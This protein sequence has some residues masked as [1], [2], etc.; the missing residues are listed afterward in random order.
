MKPSPELLDLTVDRPVHGGRC[1]AYPDGS[2]AGVANGADVGSERAARRRVVLVAGAIPG[3]RVRARVEVRKGVAFGDTVAVLAAD[4]QR[5]EPPAHPGLDLGHVAYARQLVWK[6]DVLEDALRRSGL[7]APVEGDGGG[8]DVVPSPATWGYRNAIQPAVGELGGHGPAGGDPAEATA[9][10]YRRPGGH[11]VVALEADPTA[12][13]ACRTAW[14]AL[15]A[16]R[17]P[18]GVVEVSLRG[19]DAGEALATFVATTEARA[20]LDA[21]QALV[22]AGVHGVGLAPYDARGRFR[23]G[24]QR[25]AGARTLLQR[26][27]DVELTLTATAFAQPNPAAAGALFRELA[28]WAPAARHALDLYAGSGVIG[29]H[30]APRVDRVTCLE[31]DRGAV[32]RGRADAAR[33]GLTNVQHVRLDVRDVQVPDDVDLIVVDP[34]RAGLAAATRAAIA[35]SRARTLLYV[36]C[37]VATWARDVADLTRVGFRLDRLRPYDFQPHTHHLEIASRL[38]RGGS[39]GR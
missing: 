2:E 11:D 3:E 17:L 10:G 22:A 27:G 4:G 35:G 18:R 13:E 24:A 9:L 12:N 39:A 21:A 28:A 19:N 37:D 33:L 36:A 38:V 31:I 26:Y 15:E 30:L 23:G 1:V 8:L 6:R 14:R 7:E 5:V 34:P 29:M 16:T 32:D 20:A 25:L